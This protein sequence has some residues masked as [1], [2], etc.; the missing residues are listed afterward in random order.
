MKK[1]HVL[2]SVL[3][4]VAI[5]GGVLVSNSAE[6]CPFSGKDKSFKSESSLISLNSW[7]SKTFSHKSNLTIAGIATG[8]LGLTGLGA[9]YASRR[10][11]RKAEANIDAAN[12]SMEVP[13][14]EILIKLHPE[15]PGGDLDL[16]EDNVSNTQS[17]VLADTAEKEIALVK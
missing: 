11:T 2:A 17:E 10:L 6:A 9:F 16:V 1:I 4:T 3:S 12:E 5:A 14:E 15:A 7:L 8:T 13:V